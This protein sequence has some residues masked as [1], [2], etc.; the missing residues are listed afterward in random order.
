MYNNGSKTFHT[1][2]NINKIIY[3]LKE[4]GDVIHTLINSLCIDKLLNVYIASDDDTCNLC[5]DEFTAKNKVTYAMAREQLK[6]KLNGER[7]FKLKFHG[8]IYIICEHHL[9]QILEAMESNNEEKPKRTRGA[10]K[11]QD[12]SE[13]MA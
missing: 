12:A 13:D 1:F 6:G 7:I 10:R 3:K 9:K 4:E 8:G 5:L 11:K 2:Y